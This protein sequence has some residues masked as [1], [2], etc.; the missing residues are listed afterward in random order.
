ML[1]VDAN[2]FTLGIP[3]N[4][5]FA[6]ARIPR[7]TAVE[8]TPTLSRLA[9]TSRFTPESASSLEAEL[10]TRNAPLLDAAADPANRRR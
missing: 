3:S 10:Q 8:L 1:S 4:D 5:A 6:L 9:V 7:G 2:K